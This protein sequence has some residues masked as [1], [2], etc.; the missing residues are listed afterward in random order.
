MLQKHSTQ[1]PRNPQEVMKTFKANTEP[2][3]LLTCSRWRSSSFSAP[4]EAAETA[5]R[6]TVDAAMLLAFADTLRK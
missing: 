2:E 5:A 1:N 6:R 4:F 3:K